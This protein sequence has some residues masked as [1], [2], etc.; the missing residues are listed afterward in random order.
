MATIKRYPVLRHLRSAPTSHVLHLNAGRVRHA[1]VGLAFWFLPLSAVIS[2]VPVDDRELPMVAHARTAD[3]QDVTVQIAISFQFTNP[4]LVASRLDFSIDPDSG[5]WTGE[6]LQQVAQLLGELANGQVL[7]TMATM[8]LREAVVSGG[9]AL[10][11][12]ITA[13]LQ[14]DER[15]AAL[16]I[17]VLGARV[18]SVRGEAD[19]ERFLQTPARERAQTEADKSTFE[20]RALAVESERAIAENELANKI[21]LAMREQELV[22]QEGANARARASESAAAALIE[23]NGAS[24]RQGLAAEADAHSARVVGEGQAAAEAA[25]V[26]AYAGVDTQVLAVLAVRELA[27]HLPNIANLTVTPDLLTGALAGL[28]GAKQG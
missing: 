5:A 4:A 12:V 17:A 14:A 1:G 24:E 16:G 3:F 15:L 6:P 18:R 9:G 22:T 11:Q 21:E 19:M 27:G 28:V 10:R 7:E 13:G 2:E 25:R 20:R 26:G 23:A 8:T